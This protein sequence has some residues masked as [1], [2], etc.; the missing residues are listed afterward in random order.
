MFP[1]FVSEAGRP[2]CFVVWCFFDGGQQF[3]HR[4]GVHNLSENIR[5]YVWFGF[6]FRFPEI[7]WIMKPSMSGPGPCSLTDCSFNLVRIVNVFTIVDNVRGIDSVIFLL[8]GGPEHLALVVF[9]VVVPS[10]DCLKNLFVC[11]TF[12][13]DVQFPLLHLPGIF[14]VLESSLSLGGEWVRFPVDLGKESVHFVY[15]FIVFI[16]RPKSALAV[17]IGCCSSA[18]VDECLCLGEFAGVAIICVLPE[19]GILGAL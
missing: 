9:E 14:D 2:C 3:I 12:F 8:Q 16:D 15:P 18:L 19:E 1:T 4:Y 13:Q 17:E 5:G 6:V 11:V 7:I 10:L